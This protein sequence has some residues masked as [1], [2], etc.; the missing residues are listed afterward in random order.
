M[1]CTKQS[2]PGG[3]RWRQPAGQLAAA[4]AARANSP[5]PF[6][7]WVIANIYGGEDQANAFGASIIAN[8]PAA[9]QQLRAIPNPLASSVAA[10]LDLA[11][12][13]DGPAP[14]GRVAVAGGGGFGGG[15]A[16]GLRRRRA[17]CS[18]PAAI[19]ISG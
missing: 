4:K 16:F 6:D 5:H 1:E 19:G 3:R 13:D 15:G 11:V 7:D 14:A 2:A 17:V 9:A 12:A 18:R 8:E 10:A